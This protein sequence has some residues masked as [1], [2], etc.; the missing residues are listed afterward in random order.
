MPSQDVINPTRRDG[1]LFG[2]SLLLRGREG[3]KLRR[4]GR[5]FIYI[6]QDKTAACFLGE[7]IEQR[8]PGKRAVPMLLHRHFAIYRDDADQIPVGHLFEPGLVFTTAAQS[9]VVTGVVGGLVENRFGKKV[10]D[11][12]LAF[13]AIRILDRP[14]EAMPGEPAPNLRVAGKKK[15]R[16]GVDKFKGK[17]EAGVVREV[18]EVKSELLGHLQPRRVDVS[19]VRIFRA[20]LV[21]GKIMGFEKRT[22]LRFDRCPTVAQVKWLTGLRVATAEYAGESVGRGRE[23][24]FVSF[25]LGGAG[26]GDLEIGGIRRGAENVDAP[27]W[28]L[29]GGGGPPP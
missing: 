10:S 2:E 20:I 21:R 6:R 3:R 24:D 13:G 18:V 16:A 7:A 27:V 5:S 8:L 22:R 15:H 4:I 12:Y 23:R 26:V 9:A 17:G 14:R 1:D 25:V 19:P 29:R 28:K 11:L